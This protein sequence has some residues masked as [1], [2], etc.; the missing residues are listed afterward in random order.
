MK[1]ISLNVPAATIENPKL[2]VTIR[3]QTT[4]TTRVSNPGND[5][6]ALTQQMQRMSLN[7][8]NLSAALLAQT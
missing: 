8:A 5:I 4:T 1:Q 7:Y 2:D 6:E 3:P